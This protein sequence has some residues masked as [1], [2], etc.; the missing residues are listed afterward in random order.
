MCEGG[1]VA[2]EI[3]HGL[4]VEG[5]QTGPVMLVDPPVIP[6]GFEK[7]QNTIDVRP[8][9][10]ERLYQ[11]V[12]GRYLEKT[13]DPNEYDDLPFNPD[14]PTQL[15][16]ATTV[17]MRTMVAF[18]RYIPRPFTGTA[19]VIVSE[20]RASGFLHPQ[21]PWHKLLSGR[22]IV[23]VVP[24]L[25]HELFRKGRKTVARLMKSML[26]EAPASESFVE[27]QTRRAAKP[28]REARP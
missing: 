9:L 8:D 4:Q 2:I 16:L 15:H 23:H 6:A 19:E 22:R 20:D 11:E 27:V 21:M 26:E 1:L 5:R 10:S 17:A 7:R 28:A 12:R 14:D 25:H 24:W 13:S 3:A 18:A